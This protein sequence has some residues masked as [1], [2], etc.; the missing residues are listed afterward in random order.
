[1][2]PAHPSEPFAE[3]REVTV[4]DPL[5]QGDVIEAVSADATHWQRLLLVLTADCDFAN[6]KNQGRVTCVP[7]L[8]QDE[9]LLEFQIPRIRSRVMERLI[10]ELELSLQK[11]PHSP[12][13]SRTR[14]QAW[15]LEQGVDSVM[16]ALNPP[17]IS[18]EG[19]R[20]LFEAVTKTAA[21]AN[22][23]ESAVEALIDAQLAIPRPKSASNIRKD[24]LSAL[25]AHYTSPPG[26]ALFLSAV[27][28]QH[29]D[30]Y[31]AYLRH[32]EQVAQPAI[33]LGPTRASPSYRRVARLQD[34]F[35]HAASQ[36]FGAVFMAIGLPSEYE[37]IRRLH[38]NLLG[39]RFK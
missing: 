31:F 37:E 18:A 20:Q 25:T 13:I 17:A 14:L 10:S 5:R 16:R 1:V 39:D 15:P 23:L 26:D 19:I 6:A 33:A 8:Q 11:V 12:Q 38:S 28:P 32:L 29:Q 35:I 30:G 22:D 7:L 2:H 34:R 21:P 27:A 3:F 36:Q 4:T 24:V 9:Y